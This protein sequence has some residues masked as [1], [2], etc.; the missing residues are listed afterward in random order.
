MCHDVAAAREAG[1]DDIIATATFPVTFTLD[2]MGDFVTADPVNIDWSLV[3]H[4]D[5][6][7]Q[8][9][10]PIV[11][12]DLITTV[13]TIED[14]KTMAGNDMVTLRAD[15]TDVAGAPVGTVWTTLVQ[16]GDA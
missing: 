9:H 5:Q 7:F 4:G 14:L 1:Y 10:R 16:R 6:R 15:L 8:A 12:G 3:V 13:L 2:V 11:A